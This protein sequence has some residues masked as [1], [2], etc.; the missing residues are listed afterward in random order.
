MEI[1]TT[2]PFGSRPVTSGILRNAAAARAPAPLPHAGKWGLFR[3]LCTGRA[4]FG[5]SDRDLTVLAALL[6]FHPGDML[7]DGAALIVFPSNAALSERAH[8]MAESTLRRHLAALVRAGVICRH[9]SPNGKRYA[10]RGAGG[11][12]ARAFGFDLRPILVRAPEI[13]RAAQAAREAAA[14]LRRLREEVTLLKRDAI[15]LS[16]YGSAQHPGDGWAS[17]EARLLDIHRRSRRKADAAA[18]AA[19]RDETAALLREIRTRLETMEETG[20]IVETENLDGSDGDSGRH[21][22]NS[23]PDSHC[24]EPCRETGRAAPDVPP[25]RGARTDAEPVLPLA[26]VLKACPDIAEY[27]PDDLRHWRD[28]C[29]AAD[30]VRGM[31]GVSPDA[32]RQAIAVMGHPTAAIVLLCILQRVTHIRS[33]GGY[34]RSLTAR[35]EAGEFSPGPMVMALLAPR[36]AVDSCQPAPG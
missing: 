28:L 31:L 21:Y 4:A 1:L 5:L 33:P 17:L 13:A 26:L 12:V 10:Q 24:L 34:L 3:D 14:R 19:L 20:V 15:K 27:F 7:E 32:W 25:V 8:G 9:D 29:R 22:Q 36:R 16:A 2:T 35:A 6:S 23:K 18:L 11:A 30:T